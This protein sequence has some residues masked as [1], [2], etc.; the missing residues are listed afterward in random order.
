MR[1]LHRDA[2]VK[3]LDAIVSRL[4]PWILIELLDLDGLSTEGTLD[5]LHDRRLR[6]D[7]RMADA[8]LDVPVYREDFRVENLPDTTADLLTQMSREEIQLPWVTDAASARAGVS[9]HA[10]GHAE[11]GSKLRAP[12]P[13]TSERV[14]PSE[15][16]EAIAPDTPTPLSSRVWNAL[17][18]LLRLFFAEWKSRILWGARWY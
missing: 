4:T 5:E 3:A 12:P 10:K 8:T 7:I 13:C 16:A 17:T 15:P 1:K 6:F 14:A 9:S 18:A 11:D 2:G